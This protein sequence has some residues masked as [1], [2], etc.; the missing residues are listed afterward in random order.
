MI[1]DPLY[2]ILSLPALFLT[3]GASLLLNYWYGKYS[4]VESSKGIT[5][6]QAA[7]TIANQRDLNITLNTTGGKLTDNFNPRD[8][9]VNLSQRVANEPSIASVAIAAHELGHVMQYQGAWSPVMAFRSFLV[10]AVNIGTNLGYFVIILGFIINAVGAV[11]IGIALFSLS[12]FFTLFTLPIEFDASRRAL[13]VIKSSG[14]LGANEMG[15]ARK[16]L[17]AAAL[18][19]VAAA[20]GSI[21][22][23]LY[24]VL[25]A[26]GM[27]R[28]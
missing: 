2:I 3:L 17:I 9:S 1:F 18:T 14:L 13:A 21:M 16:V 25:Q 7:S 27:S 20:A 26:R 28:D 22:N 15:G 12:T 11:W 23:L 19:Y 8:N 6:L 5:G 24:F 4:S 10:P